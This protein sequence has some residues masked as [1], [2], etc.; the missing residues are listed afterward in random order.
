MS[1]TDTATTVLLRI[2][3]CFSIIGSLLVLFSC[4]FPISNRKKPGRILLLWL[5]AT[6]LASSTVY[7]IS[8]FVDSGDAC[9]TLSLLGIFFPVASFIW[10]D[11]IAYYLYT[12]VVTSNIHRT[13]AG[14][15]NLMRLFHILAW[16]IASLCI[17]L[18]ASFGHAGSDNNTGGWC[19]V[20]AN[21]NTS[22]FVWELLGG[23]L[24]EIVSCLFV[25]PTLY[26]LAARKLFILEK[27][28]NFGVSDT[29]AATDGVSLFQSQFD[30]NKSQR[31][32]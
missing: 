23:K 11:A 9:V 30:F 22:L 8:S 13:A 4:T 5:S 29:E 3:C 7:F 20:T 27:S 17:I 32:V 16:G 24:V 31:N 14:W 6:D 15:T 2:S 25:L 1:A 18:V 21:S 26:Y 19:W 12:V 10:T 28:S